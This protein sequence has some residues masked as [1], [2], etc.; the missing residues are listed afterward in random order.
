MLDRLRALVADPP[1]TAK[2]D[3]CIRGA[4]R[5]RIENELGRLERRIDAV[6]DRGLAPDTRNKALHEARKAAKRA[7]YA[8]E[9]VRPVYGAPAEKLV[10]RLKKLQSRFGQHQDTVVTRGY[11]HDLTRSGRSPLDPAAALVAGALIER[12]S[13][14]AEQYERKAAAAWRKVAVAA[15]LPR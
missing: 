1:W 15:S 2:A 11:L 6:G 12:E 13:R 4:Y 14:D 7:R 3:K 5:R 9:P 10:K 8:V